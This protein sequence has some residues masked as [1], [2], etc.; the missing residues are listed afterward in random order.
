MLDSLSVVL[1][2]Y[3]EK[4]NIRTAVAESIRVDIGWRATWRSSWS[5]TPDRWQWRDRRGYRRR[6]WR[7]PVIHHPTN[8][9]LGGALRTGFAA[10]EKQWIL[11]IDS[12]LPIRMDDA[13]GALDL[14]RDADIVIDGGSR[15]RNRGAGK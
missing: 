14:A 1:P 12:D 8:R 3:N 15:G 9:K 6:P 2:M 4:D 10:A 13:I 11:Y 5:M 7:G